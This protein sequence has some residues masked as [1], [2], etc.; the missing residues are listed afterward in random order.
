MVKL[1]MAGCLGIMGLLPLWAQ[2][3]YVESCEIVGKV[4]QDTKANIDN[5][6]H[7]ERIKLESSFN[8]DSILFF[9]LITSSNLDF[10]CLLMV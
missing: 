1:K 9:K 10:L 8:S 2:A 4:L 7:F 6:A 3:S 5:V